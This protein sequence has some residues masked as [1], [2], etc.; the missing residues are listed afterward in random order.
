MFIVGAVFGATV[1]EVSRYIARRTQLERDDR[2]LLTIVRAEAATT[3]RRMVQDMVPPASERSTKEL[4]NGAI[5]YDDRP[6]LV[7]GELTDSGRTTG[8]P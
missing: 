5:P 1:A 3:A 4:K 8:S 2:L 7:Q 6:T